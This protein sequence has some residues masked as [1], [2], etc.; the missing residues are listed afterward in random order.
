MSKEQAVKILTCICGNRY[1]SYRGGKFEGE[2]HGNKKR[3][4]L[5]PTCSE[6]FV[7]FVY[8]WIKELG[9]QPIAVNEEGQKT[10]LGSIEGR[11]RE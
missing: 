9:K 4:D 3:F 6:I 1:P 8:E 2:Y 10:L 5:C 11:N 7:E